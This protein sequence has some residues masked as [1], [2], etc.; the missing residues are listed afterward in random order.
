MTPFSTHVERGLSRLIEKFKNKP[1]VVGL[2][3]ALLEEVQELDDAVYEAALRRQISEAFGHT[4]DLWGALLGRGRGNLSDDSYRVRLRV[5]LLLM[6]ASG[7]APELVQ[8]FRLLAPAPRT[9]HYIPRYPAAQEVAIRGA[10]SPE[11]EDFAAILQSAK[12][13]GVRST[14]RWLEAAPEDTFTTL[15]GGGKGFTLTGSPPGTGGVLS[16]AVG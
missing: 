6:R 14:L 7:T 15:G 9:V 1:K 10:P 4:L 5:Q 12:A 2:L 3:T 11:G 13:A 16:R 8:V